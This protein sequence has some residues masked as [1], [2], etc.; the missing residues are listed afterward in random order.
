MAF[1]ITERKKRG[2]HAVADSRG[3]IAAFAIDQRSALRKLFAQA[4]NT[5]AEKVPGEMLVDFKACVSRVL[6]PHASA[7]LLDPE[8]GLPATKQRAKTAGLL[9]AYEKSGYGKKVPGRLPALL[10][11]WSAR[12]LVAEAQAPRTSTTR[13]TRLSNA[14]GP[15]V[16]RLRFRFLSNWQVMERGWK[17]KALNLRGSSLKLWREPWRSFQ[18]R[19]IAWAF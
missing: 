8:Y 14:L 11:R 13:N 9:L 3:V 18:S 4:M 19:S 17:T 16:P 2:L 5:Q 6:T 12:R 7:I 10:D 1:Q 15:N